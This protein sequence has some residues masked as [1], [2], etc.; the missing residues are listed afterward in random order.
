MQKIL[1][2]WKQCPF[3]HEPV[4]VIDFLRDH[5]LRKPIYRGVVDGDVFLYFNDMDARFFAT[6]RWQ[7]QIFYEND[8]GI[9]ES[10]AQKL[11]GVLVAQ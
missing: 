10:Y 6:K 11:E 3:G 5:G 2:V 4:L 8:P 7:Y 1:A 9:K